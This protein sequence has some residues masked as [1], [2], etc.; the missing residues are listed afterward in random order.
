[1]VLA[2]ALRGAGDTRYVLYL[3]TAGNWGVRLLFS[4]ILGFVLGWGLNGVWVAMAMDQILRGSLTA[5]R[6]HSGKW[7]NIELK[8][9]SA[10]A[11]LNTQPTKVAGSRAH[12]VQASQPGS[13]ADHV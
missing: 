1:M 13:K 11:E 6:F 8:L 10:S 5:L 7:Q 9:G 4:Y 12:G 2:G 3:T